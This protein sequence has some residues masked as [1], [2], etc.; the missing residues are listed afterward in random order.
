MEKNVVEISANKPAVGHK[1]RVAAYARVSCGKDA[2]LH[3][4]MAQID[5][6]R[7]MILSNLGWEF[8]GIY[9]DEAKTG[10]REDREQ[11]QELL[12]CC[13]DGKVDMIITKSISRFA[14]NTVTLLQTVRELRSLD[15][16]VFFEEQNIHTMSAEGELMLTLLASFAQ[17]ES[18]SCS[19]NCKWRI[20]AGFEEGRPNTFRMLGYRLVEGNVVPVPEE[21]ETV[22]HIFDLYLQGFGVQHIANT[23]NDE[24]V[25]TLNGNEWRSSTVARVLDN[26]KYC[27]DLLLQKTYVP[28]HLSKETVSNKGQLPRYLIEDDH[29]AIIEKPLFRQAKAERERRA[30][31]LG[32]SPAPSALTGMIRC[33]CCGKN[34]RRKKASRCV[35]WCCGTFNTKG[36]RFCPASKMIPEETVIEA[37]CSVLGTDHYDESV[38]V[39][40]IEH[41]EAHA[42]NLLRFH[43]KN[44]F[45]A[46]YLWKDRSR[47][48]SWTPEMRYA[49]RQSTIMRNSHGE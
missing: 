12:A 3:S 4:L 37:I 13:R 46:D 2:M 10:T 5:Y 23:L 1:P 24:G 45:T 41:I 49:A 40:R 6:Y 15:V 48:E 9:A 47:A 8:A 33:G 30:V 14:R 18:L 35:K 29:E 38:F 34:Y 31:N 44:G 22:R 26:E 43:F 27:G 21:A 17:A 32:V 28:S 42:G 39:K 16:D 20:R 11:F 7:Q 25:R 19:D 36:K